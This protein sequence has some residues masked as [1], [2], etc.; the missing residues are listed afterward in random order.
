MYKRQGK[1]FTA[2][3]TVSIDDPWVESPARMKTVTTDAQAPVYARYIR[4][5]LKN[6]GALPSAHPSA[7]GTS[8]VFFDELAISTQTSEL[9]VAF[10]SSE[11]ND[12]YQV[13]F[14]NY[15]GVRRYDTLSEAVLAAEEGSGIAVL[16]DAYPDL[17]AIALTD[18]DLSLIH[19]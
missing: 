3:D 18:E 9:D 2:F 7:G 1:T 13:A 4:V 12:L 8:W 19:I 17:T 11:K 15:T 5:F 6:P 14:D 16:A 10:V